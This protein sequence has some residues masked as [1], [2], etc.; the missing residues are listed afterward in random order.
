[1]F[2]FQA[3]LNDVLVEKSKSFH[4]LESEG[5]IC[6]RSY[7]QF[8]EFTPFLS[9]VIKI[10]NYLEVSLDYLA[11]RATHNNFR[12][13]KNSQTNISQN[14]AKVLKERKISQRQLE[15]DTDVSR[16]NFVRWKN[17]SMPKFSTLVEIANYLKCS[18]DDFLEI[19]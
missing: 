2:N 3:L 5:I 11:G 16:T 10:A 18:L 7:Y 13:Y 9:T 17:G 4:D 19:E 1:M 14:I 6:E 15:R 12:R 8:D